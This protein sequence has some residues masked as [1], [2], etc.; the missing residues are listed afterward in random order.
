MRTHVARTQAGARCNPWLAVLYSCSL[1]GR[2]LRPRRD[3]QKP[4]RTSEDV[5]VTDLSVS[6][7]LLAAQCGPLVVATETRGGVACISRSISPPATVLVVSLNVSCRHAVSCPWCWCLRGPAA[8]S[9]PRAPACV[10]CRPAGKVP[11]PPPSRAPACVTWSR[12][13]SSLLASLVY[14]DHWI[15]APAEG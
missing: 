8:S 3:V 7:Y 14:P 11:H 10:T 4:S 15:I 2:R 1:Q 12:V 13:P 9:P 5:F 6:W